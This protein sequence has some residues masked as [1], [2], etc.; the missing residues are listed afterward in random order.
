MFAFVLVALL[1]MFF[2][3]PLFSFLHS[4]CM[5]TSKNIDFHHPLEGRGD[6]AKGPLDT[7]TFVSQTAW[8]GTHTLTRS[9]LPVIHM[10][11]A[12]VLK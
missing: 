8:R 10:E 4:L 11:G 6:D 12:G 5:L 3:P 9:A 2:L 1:L 7:G